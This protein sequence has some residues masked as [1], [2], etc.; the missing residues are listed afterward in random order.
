MRGRAEH[1]HARDRVIAREHHHLD[2][3]RALSVEGQQLA[4][5]GEGH[6]GL[7]R[8]VQARLL[9]GHVVA[10]V[11]GLE[12]LVL[13]LEVE[14]RPRGDGYHQLSVEIGRH[15]FAYVLVY[16]TKLFIWMMGS[17]TAITISSTTAPMP[18]ISSGSSKVAAARA[19]RCTSTLSCLAARSSICGS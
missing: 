3:G 18:T 14:Q 11:A 4:H 17:S 8:L 10:V 16:F 2:L 15:V 6:A 12:E 13:F 7:G 9:Q 5:Q 1:P 19:R